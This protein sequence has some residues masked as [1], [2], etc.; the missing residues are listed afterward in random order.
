MEKLYSNRRV[1]E[2]LGLIWAWEPALSS[3]EGPVFPQAEE[4]GRG[5]CEKEKPKTPLADSMRGFYLRGL[6]LPL[7]P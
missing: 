1:G 5:S 7:Y 4:G 3:Q 2:C 6:C